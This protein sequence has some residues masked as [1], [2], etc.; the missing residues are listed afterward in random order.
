VSNP[1]Y[2]VNLTFST[3][4]IHPNFILSRGFPADLSKGTP[5]ASPTLIAMP[6][7]FPVS[8]IRQFGLN[9]QQQLP[10]GFLLEAGFVGTRGSSLPG[11]RDVNQPSPGDAPHSI[12]VSVFPRRSRSN[13]LSDPGRRCCGGA[14]DPGCSAAGP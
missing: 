1:P 14:L 2:I 3:D 7:N 5:D 6:R 12:S 9:I 10:A 4:Q 13:C 11:A 8:M